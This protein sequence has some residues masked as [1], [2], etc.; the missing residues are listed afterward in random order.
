MN[1]FKQSIATSA[2]PAV[3][4]IRFSIGAVFLSEGIQKFLYPVALGV[5][6]FE[7]MGF[8]AAAFLAPMVGTFEIVCGVMVLAG[9]L[10]RVAAVP[11][12]AIM[13]T[14][15]MTT[16]V[17]ILVGHDLWGFHV[18]Q[19]STYGFWS[20]AHEM[21]TDLAML[22][23]SLFLLVVGGGMWS[24]DAVLQRRSQPQKDPD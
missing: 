17:Q 23:G 13:L 21:R 15:I 11:L 16:K 5:G 6:R 19:L 14:A 12:V 24:M 10:T 4:L 8:E 7:K 18:R 22:L 3:I 9:L 2:H 1:V 20:M